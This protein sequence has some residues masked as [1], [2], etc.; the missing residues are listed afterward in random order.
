MN[1][2]RPAYHFLPPSNWMNDPNGLIQWE[3][4][5]HL[6]YQYNPYA[7]V[8]GNIHW[9]HAVSADLVHWADLSIALS[10]T[11]GSVDAGGC[12]SGCA[13]DD[14]G[15]PTLI[16]TGFRDGV[17]CPCLATSQDGLLTWEKYPGNPIIS[18]PPEGLELVGFRDHTVWREDG[19]WMMGIGSGIAGVG[20][21]V[22]LYRSGDLRRWE[23]LGPLC[24]GAQTQD[25]RVPTGAMWECPSFFALGDRHVLIVSVWTEGITGYTAAMTGTY[26]DRRFNPLKI[27]KLDYGNHYFYAPQTMLDDR[28][29]RLMWGWIQEGRPVEAQVAAGWSGVM[30]LPR[31]LRLSE[32][33]ELEVSFVPE[34]AVLRGDYVHIEHLDIIPGKEGYL[35]NAGGE[36]L[37]IQV[38]L[39]RGAAAQ[40][41]LVLHRHP[42]G[43]EATRVVV[44]W[45]AERLELV[46]RH[47]SLDPDVDRT[48]LGGP[49]PGLGG[50]VAHLHLYLDHSVIEVIGNDRVAL[51]GRVYPTLPQSIGI[52]CFAV[53]G[54]ARV[55]TLDLWQLISI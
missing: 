32:D 45:Q 2:H 13:V 34:L 1:N 35:S 48:D 19:A 24:T 36:T 33:G 50:G 40:S 41:G 52:D 15:L 10:P 23:Y 30:S 18:N 46:R 53:G 3:G 28:G 9:G 8:P 7:A 20:G 49:L 39:L 17:Q 43:E 5:Y 22:L 47:S 4:Q 16:Y 42:S 27:D 21:A 44:N 55:K 14:G 54:P 31:E 29:R 26:Q 51:T 25:S 12:W 37:E 6:F 11:P 38:D